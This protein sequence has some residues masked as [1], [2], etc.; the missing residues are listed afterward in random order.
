MGLPECIGERLIKLLIIDDDSTSLIMLERLLQ[1]EAYKTVSSVSGADTIFLAQKEKP[2]LILLDVNL[3]GVRGPD[4]C[5]KLKADP[6]T[7]EIPVL[8]LSVDSGVYTKIECFDAGGQDYITK[9]YEPREVLARVK[10]HL[11][12]QQAQKIMMEML[13]SKINDLTEAQQILLPPKSDELPDAKFAVCYQQLTG[14]GGDFY[15]IVQVGENVYDYIA[16]DVCGHDLGITF[17]TAALKT[18]FAQNCTALNSPEEVLVIVNKILPAIL[19]SGQYVGV[20]WVRI[21]RKKGKA[22]ILNGGQPPVIFMPKNGQAKR[23]DLCGD[24]IG[25]FENVTFEKKEITVEAGDRFLLYSD[26]IIELEQ[27]AA[28]NRD[29]GIENLL[30]IGDKYREEPLGSFVDKITPELFNEK[31]PEDD[32]VILGV[33]V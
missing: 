13:T 5:K 20:S 23:M 18:L 1:R 10:T 22:I 6:S 26:G 28:G 30:K 19:R 27:K 15:E 31:Q 11:R 7:S 16:A 3:Q 25:I 14:A 32:I 9:P 17:I 4:I 2:D 21:N 12:L 24:L 8:F 33:D 29:P